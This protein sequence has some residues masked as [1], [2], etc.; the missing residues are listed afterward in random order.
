MLTIGMKILMTL[1]LLASLLAQIA[2][3]VGLTS[4][5]N[6]QKTNLAK[7]VPD[8]MRDGPMD[9]KIQADV[10]TEEFAIIAPANGSLDLIIIS[11]IGFSFHL[12]SSQILFTEKKYHP[13]ILV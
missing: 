11:I 6:H 9:E 3:M 7:F 8:D 1:T 5:D 2:G 10:E 13:D 12:S 4:F